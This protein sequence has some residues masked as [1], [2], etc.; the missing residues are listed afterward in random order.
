MLRKD[1]N[2]KE[3]QIYEFKEM[4][5]RCDLKNQDLEESIATLK[6]S[7]KKTKDS[8]GTSIKKLTT[9]NESEKGR[10]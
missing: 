6:S 2:E 7:L 3:N 1:Q 9:S 4:I 8:M 10:L 5:R